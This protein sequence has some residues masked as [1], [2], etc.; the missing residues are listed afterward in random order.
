MSKNVAL[1]LSELVAAIVFATVVP[2]WE[3][4]SARLIFNTQVLETNIF[5]NYFEIILNI[6]IVKTIYY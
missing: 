1:N 3:C 6:L 5:D 4:K 2:D